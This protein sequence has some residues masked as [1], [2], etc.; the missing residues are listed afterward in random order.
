M[1]TPWFQPEG[2][3][4]AIASDAG[5]GA[6]LDGETIEGVSNFEAWR[7]EGAVVFFC[8]GGVLWDF[9]DFRDFLWD[10]SLGGFP[11]ADFVDFFF[12]EF[13]DWPGP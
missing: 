13:W 12:G 4:L 1:K 10:F 9:R 5:F 7:G 6:N 2:A 3:S 8:G 11:E